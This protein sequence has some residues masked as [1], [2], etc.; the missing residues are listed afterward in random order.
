MVH[1]KLVKFIIDAPR[2]AHIIINMVVQYY[3]LPDSIIND[4]K[5][6]FTF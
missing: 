6:I 1:Y 2:L 5:T 4:Y 3:G